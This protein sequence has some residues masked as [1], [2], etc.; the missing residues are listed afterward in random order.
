[1]SVLLLGVLIL[2]LEIIWF[3]EN[4]GIIFWLLGLSFYSTFISEGKNM[5]L[6]SH[7]EI[8]LFF[9]RKSIFCVFSILVSEKL[10]WMLGVFSYSIYYILTFNNLFCYITFSQLDF[11]S[12]F[13]DWLFFNSYIKFWFSLTRTIFSFVSLLI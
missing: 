8:L 9:D 5:S 7:D 11:N 1:M 10:Y 13:F 2:K 6:L 4:D 12:R 3:N